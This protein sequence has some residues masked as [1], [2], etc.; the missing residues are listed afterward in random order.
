MRRHVALILRG[1][2]YILRPKESGCWVV[3]CLHEDILTHLYW[4]LI[5][6]Q[7]EKVKESEARFLDDVR[8]D[9]EFPSSHGTALG[10][11]AH[12]L[13]DAVQFKA[14]ILCASYWQRPD[15]QHH[16]HFG[17]CADHGCHQVVT[18]DSTPAT[19]VEG[20]V[21]DRLH[22]YLTL[23]KPMRTDESGN[24]LTFRDTFEDDK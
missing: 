19:P 10:H 12:L 8:P 22:W 7:L 13:G 20:Y 1:E 9:Q 5:I 18:A 14:H 15:F 23:L 2:G 6:Q 21:K 11:L 17:Y 24:P 16:T 3:G 4:Q